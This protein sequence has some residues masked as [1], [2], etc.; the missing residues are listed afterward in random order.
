MRATPRAA[1]LAWSLSLGSLALLVAA[2]V[3]I[4]RAWS[5]PLPEGF[6]SWPGQLAWAL[7]AVG[8]PVLGGVVAARRPENPYG[9]VWL[10]YAA[11]VAVMVWTRAYV[12]HSAAEPG[13]LPLQGFVAV[14]GDVAWALWLGLIPFLLLLFPTGRP[15]SR[16]WRWVAR[17]TSLGVALMVVPGT[18]APELGTVPLDN[19]VGL[20]GDSGALMLGLASVGVYLVLAGMVAGALSLVPRYRA[21]QTPERRQITWFGYAAALVGLFALLDPFLELPGAWDA[22]HETVVFGVL[23]LAV[24]IAILRHGLYDIDRLVNRTLVYATLT[25]CLVGTYVLVVGYLGSVF[26]GRGNA[27][28]SLFATALIAVLFAP[29]RDRLQQGVNQLMYGDRVDP[30]TVISHLARRLET[31]SAPEEVLSTIVDTVARPLDLRQVEIWYVDGT[32]LRLGA[33]HGRRPEVSTVDDVSAL[34]HVRGIA[35]VLPL[36]HQGENVGALCVAPPHGATEMS[37]GDR[38]LL[39]DLAAQVGP[40]THAVGLTAELRS[41]LAELRRSREQLVTSQQEERLRIHRDLHDGLGPVLASMRLR[42]EACLESVQDR[43]PALATDL[44]RLHELVGQAT[45]DLRSLVYDLHP[46]ALAQ[47]GL[48]GALRQ[49]C[50]RF[51]R[52]TGLSVQLTAPSE[53]DAPAATQVALFRIAQE[54]L[55]NVDKHAAA[56]SVDVS[57]ESCDAELRL[58]VRDDGAGLGGRPRGRGAGLGSMAARAELLGGALQVRSGP[59]LGVLVTVRI[60]YGEATR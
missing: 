12:S 1:L 40:A 37:A 5:A 7:G 54:A 51:A 45:A 52:E 36:T 55:L 11:A 8:A 48:V 39:R 47:L 49:H 42:L 41:S 14:A 9:W 19:P 35:Q 22:V 50:A 27:V 33:V 56:S 34:A 58:S 60:P 4:G 13:A 31:A 18:L 29:L 44:E 24:G 17:T 43:T 32:T 28:V 23:Y 46:P 6:V 30:Y 38:E 25:A 15:P 20:S 57:L 53:V 26:D 3:V 59:E 2:L 21:A 16:R 10:A